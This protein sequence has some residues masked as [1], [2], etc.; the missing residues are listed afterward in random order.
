MDVPVGVQLLREEISPQSRRSLQEWANS[1]GPGEEL[2]QLVNSLLWMLS[3]DPVTYAFT[4]TV[5]NECW[6]CTGVGDFRVEPDPDMDGTT[7]RV[8]CVY[9]GESQA[10]PAGQ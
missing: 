2:R 8:V 6:N 3:Q 4:V 10:D 9:C 1:R 7:D 5:A